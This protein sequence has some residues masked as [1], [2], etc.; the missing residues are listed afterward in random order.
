MIEAVKDDNP[1]K[2][3][4]YS[5]RYSVIAGA[6][7]PKERR[8]VLQ[9]VIRGYG[10][11]VCATPIVVMVGDEQIPILSSSRDGK[12]L[13]CL[14]PAVPAE[15]AAIGLSQGDR[16]AWAPRRFSRNEL[17]RAPGKKGKS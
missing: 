17:P 10:W 14:L 4:D 1:L 7:D 16:I 13:T 12:E 15:G 2:I 11:V 5:L 6:T 8:R 3:E 9:L